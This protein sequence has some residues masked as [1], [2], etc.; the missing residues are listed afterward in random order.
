MHVSVKFTLI[1]ILGISAKQS[2][3]LH[4]F[5]VNTLTFDDLKRDKRIF[6]MIP[7]FHRKFHE[8]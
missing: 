4:E 7:K 8:Y 5:Y 1:L 3:Q 6:Y 2:D